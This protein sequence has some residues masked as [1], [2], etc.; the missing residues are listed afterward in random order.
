MRFDVDRFLQ[1]V[2]VWKT[3]VKECPDAINTAFNFQWDSRP[4][5]TPSFDSAM[6]LHDIRYWLNNLIW[7]TNSA[8]QQR[9]D[10]LNDMSIDIMRG[11]NRAEYADFQNGTR[12]GPIELRFRGEGKVGK[13]KLLKKQWD[14]QGMFTRQLLD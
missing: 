8:S 3:L 11:P 6:S 10:E 2:D 5:K 12:T 7:Y 4:P 9:V 14:P 13:L 1:V